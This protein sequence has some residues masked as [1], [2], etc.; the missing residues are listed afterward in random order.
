MNRDLFNILDPAESLRPA[1]YTTATSGQAVDLRGADSA[2]VVVTVG[3]TTG[4]E[5]FSIVLQESDADDS[6]FE[7]VAT[8]N[9]IG[10]QP[11]A[12]AANNVYAFGYRGSKRYVLVRVV[13]GDGTNAA[14]GGV[15]IRGHLARSPADYTTS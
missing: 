12:L 13:D 3:A 11:A 9:I 6:G 15:V 2:M 7:A 1:V 4:A 10:S 14:V 5:D 8:A